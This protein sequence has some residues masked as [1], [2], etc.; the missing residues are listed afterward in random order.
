MVI[1]N[2]YFFL[3]LLL[4]G[5][6]LVYTLTAFICHKLFPKFS[7]KRFL[8]I[9]GCIGLVEFGIVVYLLMTVD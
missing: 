5:L 1:S 4:L 6:T 3:A 9:F 7:F 2:V 8:L